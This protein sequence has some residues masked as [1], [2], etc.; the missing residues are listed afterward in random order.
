MCGSVHHKN[1]IVIQLENYRK[2]E[3]T[4]NINGF[5]K[6]KVRNERRFHFMEGKVE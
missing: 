4:F 3:Y 2:L 1:G 6:C 5:R